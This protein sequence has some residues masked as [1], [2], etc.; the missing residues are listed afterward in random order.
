MRCEDFIT[1]VLHTPMG[2]DFSIAELHWITCFL[3]VNF[4][5]VNQLNCEAGETA[6]GS[7]NLRRSY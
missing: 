6:Q 7:R 2:K 3:R 4:N 1:S 5:Y